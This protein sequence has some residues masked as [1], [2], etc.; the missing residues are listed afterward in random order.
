VSRLSRFVNLWRARELD[1]DLDD[2][3]AF[4]LEMRIEKN[5][6][7]GLDRPEAEAEARR[8]LGGTLRAKEG[9]REARVMVWLESVAADVRHGVRLLLRRPGLSALAL[10]TLSLG[11][12]AN[13]AMFTLLNAL[14]LQPLPFAEPHRLM[15]VV[16]R[17]TRLG[18]SGSPTIPEIIDLR[19]RSHAFANVAFFDTRDFRM[20]GGDEPTRVF[21][22]RVSASL[23]P[24]LNVQP[25]LGR[26]FRDNENLAGHWD[27]VVLSDGL[28]RRNFGSD[29]AVVGRALTVNGTPHT[30]IG[31]LPPGF[32]VDYPA[33]S[34][35][36]PIEMY[37]PFQL[38]DAYTSRNDQFVNVRRVTTIARLRDGVTREQASAELQTVAQGI[39]AEHPELYRRA[40]EAVGFRLD[41]ES[42]HEAVTKASRS[43]LT[44]LVA[45][46]ALV[47]LIACINTGQFLLAQALDRAPEVAVRASLGAGRGRLFRQFLIE[48]SVLACAG[49][50]T[51]LIQAMWLVQLL[52]ALIPGRTP[53][54][55]SVG[56][57]RTVLA[58]TAGLSLLSALAVGVLPAIYFARTNPAARL[59]TRSAVAGGSRS[60][61]IL[62]A[63]EVA[64][65]VVLLAA[66]GLLIQGVYRLQHADR[67]FSPD[68]VTVMQIRGAIPQTTKPIP[69]IV[70]QHYVDHIAAMPGVEAAAVATPL[71]LRNPPAANFSIEGRSSDLASIE[72]QPASY[73]IVS[74]NYF[75]ALRIPLREGRVISGDDI[76]GRPRVAVINDTMARRY[77]PG[78]SS[79]GRAIRV[80]AVTLTIVGVVG[81]VQAT[82]L[83]TRPSAQ[84]YISN[85]QQFEPNMNVLVRSS[86]GSAV[87]AESIKK[88][89]WSVSPDQPVFNIQLLS[90][91]ISTSLAEQRYIAM[92]LVGFAGLA[93]F[94]SA[95]GVYTVVSYLVARRTREIAVRMAIGARA[96]DI[97][98]LV[99]AQTLGWT[100]GG[101][102]VGVAL[103]IASRGVTRTALRGAS[104]LDG[105]TMTALVVFYLAV[106][107]CAICAPVARALRCLDPAAALRAE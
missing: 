17:F 36:E 22:A 7:D 77:W 61:H 31:V 63:V 88:A 60:R 15:A 65:A 38:Y 51:G 23:F 68:D 50:A 106:A 81:D 76:P 55:A 18:V 107:G 82:P 43:T 21:T 34:G 95:T 69:S 33:L 72:R 53:L 62:V 35:P 104:E 10:L 58:F 28:W 89:I 67:G 87:T 75:K 105:W 101:L 57:D 90:Q 8:H 44:Y 93:L 37:V 85:L 78:E 52:V 71:P 66:A 2:E 45:A 64:M 11:I 100:F 26:L 25:A 103:T 40:G 91:L 27:V 30:V 6:R 56:V 39:E 16:D 1:R 80:G 29:P 19:E 12:G 41:V 32:F 84:I 24:T 74:P 46:V 54:L 94:M 86:P 97:V 3:L 42:L 49:G 79:L 98:R 47:L 73:Q 102:V 99:S 92:L 4:H 13:A 59:T 96:G 48:C 83:D 70:F 14:L 9:M 5:L 20:T